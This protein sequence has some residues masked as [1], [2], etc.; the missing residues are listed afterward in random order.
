MNVSDMSASMPVYRI[1][2]TGTTD[3]ETYLT[4]SFDGNMLRRNGNTDVNFINSV[5]QELKEA[6]KKLSFSQEQE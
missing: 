4:F 5:A 3:G 2:I 1:E 6:L